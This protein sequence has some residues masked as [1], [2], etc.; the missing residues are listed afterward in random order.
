MRPRCIV[1]V[2]LVLLA[3]S[4]AGIEVNGKLSLSK[5]I[6]IDFEQKPLK[7]IDQWNVYTLRMFWKNLDQQRSYEG[8]FVFISKSNGIRA[9]YVTFAFEGNTLTP[10]ESKNTLTFTLPTAT[11]PPAAS[12]VVIVEIVYNMVGTYMWEIGVAQVS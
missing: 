5:P 9:D 11:F 12:G 3:V 10:A 4:F 2:S 1:G 7:R 6:Q 8:S